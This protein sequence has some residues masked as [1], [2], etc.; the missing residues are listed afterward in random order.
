MLDSKGFTCRTLF[1]TFRREWRECSAFYPVSTGFRKFVG[2]S[3]EQDEAA[4]PSMAAANRA[5]I[6]ATAGMLPTTSDL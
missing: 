6:G 4:H 5:M 3:T 2:F 1:K